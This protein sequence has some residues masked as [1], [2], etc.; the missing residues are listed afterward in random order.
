MLGDLQ[1]E[2]NLAK[3]PGAACLSILRR[4]NV[5]HSAYADLINQLYAWIVSQKIL[6]PK[7]VE[8][9]DLQLFQALERHHKRRDEVVH[10]LKENQI[11]GKW[12]VEWHRTMG[13]KNVPGGYQRAFSIP[14]LGLTCPN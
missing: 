11:A 6:T 3:D 9:R 2:I 4:L 8:D 10:T 14:R 7:D 5:E 12:G 1:R 13:W